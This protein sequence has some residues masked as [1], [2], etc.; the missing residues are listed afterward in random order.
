MRLDARL[1]AD[2]ASPSQEADRNE[3]ALR[4]ARAVARLPADQRRAVE[5][6]YLK[7]ATLAEVADRLGRGKRA[8]AGL[9]FRGIKG[10]RRLLEEDG[11]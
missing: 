2:S 3:Q 4:L 8:A 6:H 7:G 1:A 10:L 11:S 5:L 9:I